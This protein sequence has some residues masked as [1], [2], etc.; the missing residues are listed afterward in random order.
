MKTIIFA[1]A[2]YCDS[3]PYFSEIYHKDCIHLF[4]A[5]IKNQIVTVLAG[6]G[7]KHKY[8]NNLFKNNFFYFF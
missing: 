1:C 2:K 5:A 3:F 8:K 7:V 4:L 6:E